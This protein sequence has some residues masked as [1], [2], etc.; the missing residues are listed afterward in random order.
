M[1]VTTTTTAASAVVH[2]T[3]ERSG[4]SADVHLYGATVTSFR[5]SA[6][7]PDVLFVSKK[8]ILDGSKPIRGG[9]PLVFPQ[10]GA[11]LVPSKLPSHGFARTST[12]TLVDTEDFVDSVTATFSLVTTKHQL[13]DWP[14]AVRLLYTVTL[15]QNHLTTAL[16]ITNTDTESWG[17]QALLH[18][19]FLVPDASP[20]LVTS[21]LPN[22][23]VS[24][25]AGLEYAC[26]V[27]KETLIESR[28][29]VP[30][31]T[32]T[33]SV[34]KDTPER[35]TVQLGA[36]RTVRI[37]KR[38]YVVG[39]GAVPSDAVVWNPWLDK[40]HGLSDFAD[41]EYPT[42]LCVEPGVVTRVQL[43]QPQETLVLKQT[44]SML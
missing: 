9:I 41:D 8:A 38:A 7:A 4:A 28:D 24:G 10:F 25:L 30:I 20:S 1:P 36:S 6:G 29:A 5:P 26:K 19:Y 15:S 35:L 11:G 39:N 2:L 37:E 42:M 43:V 22:V 44:L 33:D 23:T 12:W 17:C 13:V 16:H 27:R 14:H 18:T 3:H 34:Y 32:E 21:A 40:A 31:E